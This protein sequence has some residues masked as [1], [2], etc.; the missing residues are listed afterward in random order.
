MVILDSGAHVHPILGLEVEGLRALELAL[1]EEILGMLAKSA[2]VFF[3]IH[4]RHRR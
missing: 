2:L 4:L 1:R 3:V